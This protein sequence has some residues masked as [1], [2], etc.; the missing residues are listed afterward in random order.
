M[1]SKK[2]IL[3][4]VLP[5][6][7]K[8]STLLSYHLVYSLFENRDQEI[9]DALKAYQNE[10]GGFG[11]GL[12][13][14]IQMPHSSVA[15]TNIAIK[16][17]EFVKDDSI[18]Q[19]M[20][21]DIVRYCET[22]YDE[23][24]GRFFMCTK[25]VNEYPH[26]IWWNFEDIEAEKS[27]PFGNPD[28]EVIG[29]L[30]ENRKY[31]TKLNFSTLINKVVQFVLSDQFMDAGMHSLMSVILFYKRVD[32][33]VK[34]LIH[35]RI[36]QLVR[37][38]LNESVGKWDEYGLEPYKIYILEPHFVNT[39][40]ELLGENLTQIIQKISTLSVTPNWNWHQYQE[41]FEKVKKDWVG[42]MYFD[43]IWS[44]RLHHII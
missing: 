36:H 28:P 4:T 43:M 35:D 44:L 33:D 31:L 11:N 38:E 13:P 23:K 24:K 12:E 14:D 19:S 34:N 41:T 25:E 27:F 1:I 2:Y 40:L 17:L 8:E 26:A 30:Y 32:D 29:F 42:L 18:K 22:V 10:D 39:H 5:Y 9:I 7:K 37:K 20:I 16:A 21:K 3:D 6:I 15:A